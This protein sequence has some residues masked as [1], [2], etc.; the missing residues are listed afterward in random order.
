MKLLSVLVD[1][2]IEPDWDT[3]IGAHTINENE[4]MSLKWQYIN[5]IDPTQEKYDI[6]KLVHRSL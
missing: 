3:M 1:I 4:K 2:E 5:K 6:R